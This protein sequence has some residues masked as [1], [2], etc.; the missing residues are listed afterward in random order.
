MSLDKF[1]F[2]NNRFIERKQR[3][4]TKII[5]KKLRE[6]QTKLEGKNPKESKNKYIQ[7]LA[8]Y[9]SK[10]EASKHNKDTKKNLDLLTCNTDWP[11]CM[12]DHSCNN[13]YATYFA[14][15]SANELRIIE[16]YF[17]TASLSFTKERT[18]SV[19]SCSL[20]N[21]KRRVDH[22][23]LY[24]SLLIER[25]VHYCCNKEYVRKITKLLSQ[26]ESEWVFS[27]ACTGANAS[28]EIGL[29]KSMDN[30]M[31][32]IMDVDE[33]HEH[34]ETSKPPI[35]RVKSSMG[36]YGNTRG[37]GKKKVFKL[38]LYL[39]TISPKKH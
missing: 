19:D 37:K 5:C 38:G 11:I 18:M 4:C 10:L 2:I 23:Q 22:K 14:F 20:F 33:S 29:L 12:Y 31:D 30:Y 17:D 3:I 34:E 28:D 16:D 8:L 6:S 15:R 36:Y 27:D 1:K 39:S 35:E 26:D 13:R 24:N 32:F 25:N 7:K 21:K 9:S